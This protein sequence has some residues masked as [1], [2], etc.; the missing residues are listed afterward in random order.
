VDIPVPIAVM[1]MRTRRRR[2]AAPTTNGEEEDFLSKTASWKSAHAIAFDEDQ[3]PSIQ[4]STGTLPRLLKPA[5]PIPSIKSRQEQVQPLIH[6]GTLNGCVNDTTYITRGGT[7]MEINHT[8]TDMWGW[9]TRMKKPECEGAKRPSM[10]D[11]APSCDD[12]SCEDENYGDDDNDHHHHHHH[13]HH[14]EREI[15]PRQSA[16]ASS[17]SPAKRRLTGEEIYNRARA[18]PSFGVLESPRNTLLLTRAA[19]LSNLGDS[20]RQLQP[21]LRP[22]EILGLRARIYALGV[23]ADGLQEVAKLVSMLLMHFCALED[24][25][26]GKMVTYVWCVKK[27]GYTGG[28]GRPLTKLKNSLIFSAIREFFTFGNEPEEK[29]QL[30]LSSCVVAISLDLANLEIHL[31]HEVSVVKLL[32]VEQVLTCQS[33]HFFLGGLD[34]WCVLLRMR[35]DD[36]VALRFKSHHEVSWF[37]FL[38]KLIIRL[39]LC[40]RSGAEHLNASEIWALEPPTCGS[41][42]YC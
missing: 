29:P 39:H 7:E 20:F 34:E 8:E 10:D 15:V 23:E 21:Q 25:V 41:W 36:S 4:P 2:T 12:G 1:S 22:G 9:G 27:K 19:S 32:Q 28:K 38:L 24:L 6:E 16:A 11:E 37:A 14:L 30:V 17:S 3:L 35:D 5:G 18:A 40:A 42:V 26:R 13:H 33:S 31:P